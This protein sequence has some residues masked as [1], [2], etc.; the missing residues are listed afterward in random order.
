[1]LLEK[2]GKGKEVNQIDADLVEKAIYLLQE[3][4]AKV[5]V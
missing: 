3:H 1:M 5:K 4:Q 2:T